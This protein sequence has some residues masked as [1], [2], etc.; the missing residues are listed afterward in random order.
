MS[1]VSSAK[2]AKQAEADF[3]L[4]IGKVNDVGYDQLRYLHASKNKLMGDSDTVPD[5]RHGRC[6]CLIDADIARYRDIG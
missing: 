2:T 6:E 1:H 3:I 5:L 4:G